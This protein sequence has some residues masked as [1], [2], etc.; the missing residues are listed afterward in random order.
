MNDI[1]MAQDW[2]T[3]YQKASKERDDLRADMQHLTAS[4]ARAFDVQSNIVEQTLLVEEAKSLAKKYAA[5]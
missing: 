4:V 3:L 1:V 5:N 2:K